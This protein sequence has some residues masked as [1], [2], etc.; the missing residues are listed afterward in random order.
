M[1]RTKQFAVLSEFKSFLDEI[2]AKTLKWQTVCYSGT[3]NNQTATISYYASLNPNSI[4]DIVL[5]PGLATNSNLDPLIKNIMFWGLNHRRNIITIDTFLGDFKEIPL[6]EY[7]DKNTYPEFVSL[8]EQSIIFIQPY[9]IPKKNILIGH[10]AG[11][12]G[13]TDAINNLTTKNT[14]INAGSV[15]LF[16]P[17]FGTQRLDVINKQIERRLESNKKDMPQNLL[18]LINAFDVWTSGKIR[19]VYI[20]SNFI[21]DLFTIDFRPDLMNKWNTNVTLVAAQ[22]DEK[23]SFQFLQQCYKQLEQQSNSDLFR[24]VVL[25]NTPHSILKPKE[26][27]RDVIRIVKNQKTL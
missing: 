9:T 23:V 5:F 8:I 10:S 24:F 20:S 18:S 3:H 27:N 12:T 6:A 13:L 15:M 21:Q 25:Q 22:Q 2:K 1:N 26:N 14:K 17:C 16:A 19:H 4:G 11:A 7:A